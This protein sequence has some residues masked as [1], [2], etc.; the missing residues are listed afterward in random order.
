M[1][2]LIKVLN[3]DSFAQ[4]KSKDAIFLLL[5]QDYVHFLPALVVNTG[6]KAMTAKKKTGTIKSI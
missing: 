2:S 4:K 5:I 1:K 3:S 6:I